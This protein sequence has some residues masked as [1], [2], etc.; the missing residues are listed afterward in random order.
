MRRVMC[1]H[2]YNNN[3]MHNNYGADGLVIVAIGLRGS[4]MYG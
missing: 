4:G 1:R 3:S 2:Y